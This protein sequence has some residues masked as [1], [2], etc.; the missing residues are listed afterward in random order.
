MRAP[1]ASSKTASGSVG[2]GMG[3]AAKRWRN[4]SRTI[5]TEAAREAETAKDIADLIVTA[6]S[7]VHNDAALA[8]MAAEMGDKKFEKLFAA[9]AALV[10][11]RE[12]RKSRIN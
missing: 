8:E 12:H 1:S 10:K 7:L 5:P 11:S 6:R 2:A 3:C 9:L 4:S